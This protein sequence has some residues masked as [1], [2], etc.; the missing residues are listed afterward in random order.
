MCN[1][2][3][4]GGPL[5]CVRPEGHIDGHEYHATSGSWL[6]DRHGDATHG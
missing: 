3:L 6:E 2:T 4:A 1:A 5:G